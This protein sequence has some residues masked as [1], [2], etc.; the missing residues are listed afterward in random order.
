MPDYLRDRPQDVILHCLDRRA[1]STKFKDSDIEDIDL[2]N[3]E[4]K[5]SGNS[6]KERMINFG[7][8]AKKF[9]VKLQ[10]SRLGQVPPNMQTLFCN[11]LPQTKLVMEQATKSLS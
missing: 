2:N 3:G 10:L 11:F 9:N 4:F 6:N 7:H 1:N 8:K 5:I